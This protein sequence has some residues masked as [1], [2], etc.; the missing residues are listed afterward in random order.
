M[1]L[2]LFHLVAVLF[3]LSRIRHFIHFT[4]KPVKAVIIHCN[5]TLFFIGFQSYAMHVREWLT[6]SHCNTMFRLDLTLVQYT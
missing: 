1:F 3:L 5:A 2:K 4:C 6:P